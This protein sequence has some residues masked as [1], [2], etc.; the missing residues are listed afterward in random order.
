MIDNANARQVAGSHYKVEDGIQHWDLIDDHGVGYLEGCASKYVTRWRSKNGLQDLE[1][2]EHY[3]QKLYQKR[4]GLSFQ[5]Q[6]ERR[7]DVPADVILE[8]ARANACGPEETRI[9]GLILR[10]ESTHTIDLARRA[11]LALI[12]SE[13][14]EG[15]EASIGYVNQDR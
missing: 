5:E 2:C 15:A 11:V 13:S 14:D 4:A 3:L 8:F 12:A 10:W 1:K 9:L 6:L 7:P